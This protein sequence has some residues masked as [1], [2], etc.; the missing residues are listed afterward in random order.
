MRARTEDRGPKTEYF[1]L[2][3]AFALAIAPVTLR[4]Q[5]APPKPAPPATGAQQPQQPTP[6]RRKALEIRGQ[7][8]APEVVTVRP[9][10]IPQFQR[11]I[12]TPIL[13]DAPPAAP[14]AAYYIVLPG[15]LPEPRSA[16]ESNP[17]PKPD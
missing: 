12:L 9:R 14:A 3:L 6:A 17:A 4:A 10:E 15:P 2:A 11:K 5:G 7:A 8:P 13:Y 1:G 16:A